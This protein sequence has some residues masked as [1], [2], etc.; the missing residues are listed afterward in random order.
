[1]SAQP[2][3]RQSHHF[4]RGIFTRGKIMRKQN[5]NYVEFSNKAMCNT[6]D[7]AV[8]F[9]FMGVIFDSVKALASKDPVQA[10][11]LAEAGAYWAE[12][13]E[14]QMQRFQDV[15]EKTDKVFALQ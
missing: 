10:G 12:G 2:I 9:R 13:M 5:E 15:I 14:D 8:A 3:I 4:D 11:L 6:A 1:M 7:A